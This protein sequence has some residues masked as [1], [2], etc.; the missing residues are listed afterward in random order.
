MNILNYHSEALLSDELNSFLYNDLTDI[1]YFLM[2]CVTVA[3]TVDVSLR[4]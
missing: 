1:K 3:C 4:Y 2:Y